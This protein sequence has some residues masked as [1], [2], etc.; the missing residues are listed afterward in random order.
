MKMVIIQARVGSTR[1]PGKV[2]KSL[3]GQPVLFHVID[4][5]RRARRADFVTVA[6]TDKSEDDA[7]E[8]LCKQWNVP[9]FRGSSEDVL[10]RFY[11]AAQ[12]LN[13]ESIVRITA[14]CP[15]IAPELIDECITVFERSGADYASN[16]IS[17]PRRLISGLDVEVFSFKALSSA[18]TQAIDAHDREH[19]TPYMRRN[20]LHTFK[21]VPVPVAEI[22]EHPFR[23]TVD[24]P[25]DMV[26][27]EEL[28]A[29][30][31]PRGAFLETR[32]AIAFLQSHQD[33]ALINRDSVQRV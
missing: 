29:A 18:H 26:L 15:L 4:R 1:L 16:V 32:D 27:M 28:Y 11:H 20:P 12:K 9:C 17:L 10:S 23:L 31:A 14:D 19:V 22:Y 13:A 21:I 6:T 2:L 30:L 8:E 25:E 3:S 5:C 33:I 7:I 24:Y